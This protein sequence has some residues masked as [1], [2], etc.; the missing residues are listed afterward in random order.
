LLAG[1]Y[2]RQERFADM[3]PVLQGALERS[4]E[5]SAADIDLHF[6]LG[7]A[8]ERTSRY[9]EADRAF[10]EVLA[11]DPDDSRTLNYLG[12]MWAEQG[13]KLDEALELIERAVALEPD[14]GAYVDS[15]GWVYYQLGRYDEARQQLE[16]A[17]ELLPEDAT[18]LEH[19]GDVY[20]QLELPDKARELY[21]R[22]AARNEENVEGVR[23]KLAQLGT[24]GS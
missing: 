15:L 8:L 20:V 19:L 9:D 23:R 5:D 6:S 2:Q 24:G 1:F 4:E 10:R 16:R 18:I 11:I 12:Y 17:A 13:K 14:T 22:A 3:V 7:M 21:Q